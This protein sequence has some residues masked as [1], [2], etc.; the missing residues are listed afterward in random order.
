MV[1]M[2]PKKRG[3][4][5]KHK[6]IDQQAVQVL[7]RF[8]AA[9]RGLIEATPGVTERAVD[10]ARTVGVHPT[11]A[12]KIHRL[13]YVEDPL[14]QAGNMPG[15]TAME[16]FLN[17]AAKRGAPADCVQAVRDA[18]GKFEKLIDV[19]AGGRSEFDSIISGL[20]EEGSE[21]LDLTHKRAAFKADSH[22]LGVQAETHVACYIFRPSDTDPMLIDSA[23]FRGLIGLRRFRRDVSWIISSMRAT[24]DDG[25]LREFSGPEPM[26]S[27][28][29]AA[30]VGLMPEF[31]SKP[32]PKLKYVPGQGGNVNVQVEPDGLGATSAITCM[33]GHVLRNCF[34]RYRD[35][36]NVVQSCQTRVRTPCKLLVHDML[37]HEG[38]FGSLPPKVLVYSD[39][40]GVDPILAGRECD[41]LPL[42]ETVVNLGRGLSA[43]HT[44]EAPRYEEMM[45]Y[46]F[47]RTGWDITKFE[48]WRCRVEY[49]VMPS[50]VVVLFDLP[51]KPESGV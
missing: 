50:S 4:G 31:C 6:D 44:P 8:Q 28:D 40:R 43:V 23:M 48:V 41:L 18:Q 45:K 47:D 38:M 10:L 7:G 51:E 34:S 26:A 5:P 13:A 19:H 39:H 49:P 36:T 29:E 46:A 35:E 42:R 2:S 17:A 15:P 11:L 21:Q 22:F 3:S 9:V 33:V 12:W 37:I 24:N 20:S 16:R 30:G 27:P 1:T 32:L 14:T 25:S